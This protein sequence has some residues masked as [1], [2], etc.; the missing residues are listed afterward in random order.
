MRHSAV[1][2][3][4]QYELVHRAISQLFEKQL[5]LLESPT[6][7]EIHVGMDDGLSPEKAGH[8]S[9][10][11][12]WDTPPPKPPRIRSSQLEG[13]VKEEILQPPEPRPVPPIL[14]P[15]PPSAFPTVTNVRQDNDRYH[16][17]PVI[18]V[19]ASAQQQ[20]Q[21]QKA[22][23]APDL[24]EN[25]NKTSLDSVPSGGPPAQ[26]PSPS[27]PVDGAVRLE[28]KLSIEIQKVPLQE[29]PKSFDGNSKLHRSLAFKARSNTSSS[30]LSEDSGAD[31][32]P[33]NITHQ[34][35][36]GPLPS[37]PNHLPLKGEK[38]GQ[39][40]WVSPEKA[41]TPPA[42]V[43][44]SE[45][46][47][48][49]NLSS[50]Q[51]LSSTSTPVR[52]ALSFTNPLHSDFPDVKGDGGGEGSRPSWSSKATATVTAAHGEHPPRKVSTMSIAEQRS[53]TETASNPSEL[54]APGSSDWTISEDQ[55]G[56][57]FPK[58][59]RSTQAQVAEREP[60]G[61]RSKKISD[62]AGVETSAANTTVADSTAES[63]ASSEMGYGNRCTQPKGP[64]DPP[65]QWT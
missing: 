26:A 15:S 36:F 11:E 12:R 35:A 32:G 1:Q 42:L 63:K 46:L 25:Y 16:P 24:K 28:R 51:P 64:R 22:Q 34:G 38:G 49:S 65:T 54:E 43:A 52:T 14:T 44:G 57:G 61:E 50:S 20:Q 37:R 19:L 62:A 13:D 4:E 60:S 31:G 23:Q 27:S 18:H 3:K 6:N 39:A 9:D 21:P 56:K 59:Q 5:Q 7:S 58:E 29:G 10:E 40:G 45:S 53:P 2:T 33:P 55:S 47:P 41:P 30:S 8:H 17:K 48:I